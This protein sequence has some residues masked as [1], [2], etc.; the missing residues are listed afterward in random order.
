MVRFS[1]VAMQTNCYD[2]GVYAIVNA[3]ALVY[4][5]NHAQQVYIPHV[6]R[7]HLKNCLKKSHIDPIPTSTSKRRRKSI[8]RTTS[9]QLFCGCKMRDT[10]S[11]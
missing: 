5:R 9:I 3:T 6:M 8:K 2:R 1:S 7:G 11:V 4:G 10:G